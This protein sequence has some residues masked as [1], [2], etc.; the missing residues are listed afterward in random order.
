VAGKVVPLRPDAP[1]GAPW[2]TQFWPWFLIALPAAAVVASVVTLF[3]AVRNAD[4]VV[5]PDYYA[6]GLNINKQLAVD[7]AAA[8]RGITAGVRI[9]TAGPEIVVDVTGKDLGAPDVLLLTLSHP[10]HPDRDRSFRLTRAAAGEYRA[11]L[12]GM[13]RGHWYARLTPPS[14]DW[15]LA[16]RIDFASTGP[17]PIGASR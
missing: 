6:A 13:L 17:L 11:P 12:D 10:T 5:R 9:D 15:R 2:Y 4:S 16:S 1:R 3:I 14:A 7:R 8:D